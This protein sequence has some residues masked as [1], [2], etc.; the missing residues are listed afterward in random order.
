MAGSPKPPR[1][2][3]RSDI[4]E[5]IEAYLQKFDLAAERGARRDDIR[6][7]LLTIGFERRVTIAFS[8]TDD[9]VTILRVFYGGQDW[10]EILQRG[11]KSWSRAPQRAR[12]AFRR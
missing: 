10:E 2:T 1:R 4:S 11:E 3:S 9:R 7:G 5:R 8:A 6:P 12:A